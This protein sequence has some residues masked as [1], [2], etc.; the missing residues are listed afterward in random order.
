MTN[1]QTQLVIDSLYRK[2][3]KLSLKTYNDQHTQ[4]LISYYFAKIHELKAQLTN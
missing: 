3:L 4:N 2:A 1:E